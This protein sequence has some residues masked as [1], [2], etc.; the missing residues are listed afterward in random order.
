[1]LSAPSLPVRR[2]FEE[3]TKKMQ[4][5][6]SLRLERRHESSLASSNTLYSASDQTSRH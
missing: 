2:R 4:D 5:M 3:A 1:V 6:A